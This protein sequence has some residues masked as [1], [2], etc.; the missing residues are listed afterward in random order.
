MLVN[1]V[2]KSDIL[3]APIDVAD[4]EADSEC[5]KRK[6]GNSLQE[7]AEKLVAQYPDRALKVI[8]NWMAEN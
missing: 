1:N 3:L 5:I 8:R 2:L 6:I 7:K 4:S